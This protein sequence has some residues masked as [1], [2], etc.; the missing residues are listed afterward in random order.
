M[1]TSK[2]KQY[3]TDGIA[4]TCIYQ[5]A[6]TTQTHEA[7]TQHG[8]DPSSH[9]AQVDASLHG[10]GCKTPQLPV[11]SESKLRVGTYT[12]HDTTVPGEW[13]DLEKMQHSWPT[14]PH[15][16]YPRNEAQMIERNLDVL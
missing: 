12:H 5:T 14:H 13:T 7:A 4:C 2:P 16:S 3:A 1:R 11:Q 8:Y 10:E 6:R 9:D 15:D